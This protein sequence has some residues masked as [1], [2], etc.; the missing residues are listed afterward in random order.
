MTFITSAADPGSWSVVQVLSTRWQQS[1][2]FRAHVLVLKLKRDQVISAGT[3]PSL[4]S[5]G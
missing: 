2:I 3:E 5:L 1:R 4:G